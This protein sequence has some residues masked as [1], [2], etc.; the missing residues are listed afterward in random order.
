[1][2]HQATLADQPSLLTAHKRVHTPAAELT[3]AIGDGFASLFRHTTGQGATPVG[4]PREI[5]LTGVVVPLT[6]ASPTAPEIA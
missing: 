2:T 6:P 4:P 5:D 3:Q 1:M